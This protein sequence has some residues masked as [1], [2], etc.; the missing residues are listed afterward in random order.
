[1]AALAVVASAG[2]INCSKMKANNTAPAAGEELPTVAEETEAE[3]AA[4]LLREKLEYRS[5]LVADLQAMSAMNAGEEACSSS[6]LQALKN[7]QDNPELLSAYDSITSNIAKLKMVIFGSDNM[8]KDME[9]AENKYCALNLGAVTAD[10]ALF[11]FMLHNN[12]A[13]DVTSSEDYDKLVEKAEQVV[14][15]LKPAMERIAREISIVEASAAKEKMYQENAQMSQEIRD[16]ISQLTEMNEKVRASYDCDETSSQCSDQT[17][18]FGAATG[19]AVSSIQKAEE[20]LELAKI[21][22]SNDPKIA[23]KNGLLKSVIE[24]LKKRV[25]AAE[26]MIRE[27]QPDGGSA[28]QQA[29]DAAVDKHIDANQAPAVQQ[30][31]SPELTEEQKRNGI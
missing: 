24:D 22:G 31:S 9:S 16:L 23:Q 10:Y 17:K 6:D 29:A 27:N 2:L 7:K 28:A 26:I 21:E 30:P 15:K 5:S 4:R 1:M 11:N 25:A 8:V 12:Q 18:A 14:A 20:A 3:R 13:I 19:N